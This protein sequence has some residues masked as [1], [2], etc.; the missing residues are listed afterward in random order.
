MRE[1]FERWAKENEW[2][3]A[4][5]EHSYLNGYTAAAWIGWQASRQSLVVKLPEGDVDT[6]AYEYEI[7]QQMISLGVQVVDFDGRPYK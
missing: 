2:N 7:A 4:K 3:T 5:H 6:G 1:E